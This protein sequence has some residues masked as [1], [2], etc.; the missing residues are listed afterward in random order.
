[1]ITDEKLAA[2]YQTMLSSV[3]GLSQHLISELK[4]DGKNPQQLYVV[5]LYARLHELACGAMALLETGALVGVP[6]LLRAMFECDVDLTNA[7]KD[8]QYYKNI[9][10]SFLKEQIKLGS[11]AESSENNP[12]FG[13]PDAKADILVR[14]QQL[15][16]ELASLK[17]EDRGPLQIYDRALRAEK[18]QEYQT[19][20]NMLCGD[21]HNSIESLE[22]WHVDKSSPSQFRVTLFRMR[23]GEILHYLSS[24]PG[25][26]LINAQ[27]VAEF[28]GVER[29]NFDA[30]F[31]RFKQLHSE[32]TGKADEMRD[33]RLV[34]SRAH[35][36]SNQKR[37]R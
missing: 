11:L 16:K 32:L 29:I 15:R 2:E 33:A 22:N 28:Y 18:L 10:S 25:V 20:Y 9:R 35:G 37:S 17:S 1:M 34:K 24:I 19:V 4:F 8:P 30:Y 23:K 21:T 7:L 3:L 12:Y 13:S 6:L 36:Q 5:Y 26:L 27:A 31:H 14:L